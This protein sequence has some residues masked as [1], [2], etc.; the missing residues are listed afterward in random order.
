[1]TTRKT[2]YSWRNSDTSAYP[3]GGEKKGMDNAPAV[4]K[5]KKG[6]DELGPERG[7]V[8]AAYQKDVGTDESE[9]GRKDIVSS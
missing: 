7:G 9:K 5:G 3:T 4:E 8:Y 6:D 1:L 2:E